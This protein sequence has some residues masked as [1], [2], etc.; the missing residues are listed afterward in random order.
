MTD[1][2]NIDRADVKAL[3]AEV[4]AC[5]RDGRS[6]NFV[7]EPRLLIDLADALEALTAGPNHN[8][9]GE[10]KMWCVTHQHTHIASVPRFTYQ[11]KSCG[12]GQ[13]YKSDADAHEA[14][15]EGHETYEVEHVMVPLTAGPRLAADRE[16]VARLIWDAHQSHY[17]F[18]KAVEEYGRDSHVFF[19]TDAAVDALFAPGVVRDVATV[20]AEALEAA[21]EA[22]AVDVPLG[23]GM[24][25][26]GTEDKEMA[27]YV[28]GLH[29]AYATVSARA[30]TLRTPTSPNSTTTN[31]EG[32]RP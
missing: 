15:C 7:P 25:A 12:F 17:P 13:W 10:P 1:T 9:S 16:A 23:G 5:V 27:A 30:A 14:A 3:V 2:D 4:R 11:C 32:A 8:H 6:Y 24:R 28:E 22:I 29:V 20:Q 19:E 18:D 21:A 31:N 26:D